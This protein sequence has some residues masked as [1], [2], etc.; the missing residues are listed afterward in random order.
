MDILQWNVSGLL[1]HCAEFKNLMLLE[2]PL[3]AAIQETHLRDTDVYNFSIKGYTM[4]QNNINSEY[5]KGGV[6]LYVSN[7]L[8]QRRVNLQTPL[9]AVAVHLKL[10][11]LSFIAVSL[12]LPPNDPQ[13]TLNNLENLVTELSPS[14]VVLLGDFNAHHTMWGSMSVSPR[15]QIIEKFLDTHSLCFLNDCSPTFQS[16]SYRSLS[17]IDLSVTSAHLTQHFQWTVSS[18]PLF[19]DHFPISIS[20]PSLTYLPPVPTIQK[21]KTELADWTKFNDKLGE[22][23]HDAPPDMTSFLSALYDT[24]V[25]IIPRS[26]S[27]SNPQI[28]AT[29][30]V[31]WNARCQWAKAV[32]RRALRAFEKNLMDDLLAQE[33]SDSRIFASNIFWEEKVKSWRTYVGSKINRFTPLTDIWHT[34]RSFGS[35]RTP[36]GAFPQLMTP[37]GIVSDPLQ[38]TNTFAKHFASISSTTIYPL[39]VQQNI[40]SLTDHLDFSSTET[41]FYNAPFTRKELETSLAKSNKSAPGPDGIDYSF[42]TNLTNQNQQ[43]LLSSINHLW[44][45]GTFPSEW[46]QS[47]IIPIKKEG[48]DELLAASYRPISLTNCSCKIMERMVNARLT[49][50]MET[51]KLYSPYQSGFRKNL[52]TSCNIIRL[53]SSVQKGFIHGYP[54]IATFLDLTSAFNKVH[55]GTILV[56]LNRIGIRGHMAKFITNFLQPRTFQ[57]KCKTTI[58]DVHTLDHGVP[59]GSVLSP[60]LFLLAI[61][62]IFDDIHRIY[63]SVHCSMFADDLAIWVT[64]KSYRE[65][66]E[67][68][69]DALRLISRWCERWGFFLSSTKSAAMV[70]KRGKSSNDLQLKIR[71]QAIPQ[72][73]KFKYLGILL[74]TRLTFHAH[75][76]ELRTRCLQRMN[77]LKCVSG[78]T[79]G[80]DRKSLTVL[81]CSLIRS[82]LDY[83]ATVI[84]VV[85]AT[86]RQRIES[87]QSMC[88]R[89][90][91]GAFRSTAV[92]ALQ[93]DVCLP[94]LENR[95]LYLLLRNYFQVMSMPNHPVSPCMNPHYVYNARCPQKA[96]RSIAIVAQSAQTEV[97]MCIPHI[98]PKPPALAY[99]LHSLPDVQYLINYKKSQTSTAE[100]LADF[101]EFQSAHSDH[102]FIY[103]DGSLQN[104]QVGSAV[105]W[106]NLEL[107]Y[108]LPDNASVYTAELYAIKR[109]MILVRDSRCP[110][111]VICTDSRSAL[112]ALQ[113]PQDIDHPL[114]YDILR[115]FFTLPRGQ[116]ITLLWI[117]GHCSIPG[118]ERADGA[119]KKGTLLPE[120]TNIKLP[121]CDVLS[122]LKQRFSS[123]LQIQW[124][125]NHSNHLFEIKPKLAT[126]QTSS[127][128]TRQREVLLTRLRCG[129]TR[130][131]HSYLFDN[132]PPPNCER[133]GSRLSVEHILLECHNEA[134]RRRDIANYLSANNLTPNLQNLLGNDHPELVELVLDFVC[135]STWAHKL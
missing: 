64:R 42:Y 81:Y 87:I 39:S 90:I 4:Y 83:S 53:I 14:P 97:N 93:A 134:L 75:I 56:K 43:Q 16:R 6:A 27:N 121:L 30:A 49:F 31:W 18:D 19:S 124:E 105:V 60:N 98:A 116:N 65:S 24:A 82:V 62:D 11:N 107:I 5:R 108:R 41:E 111:S 17:A 122:T 101:H 130:L 26:K 92:T 51:N 33:Y 71:N 38:V 85:C 28:Q 123:Y 114:V 57:V 12:Y 2:T 58:S 103:T 47:I 45:N 115:I 68:M 48:K 34:V 44:V 66:H 35:R 89:I 54:T 29:P 61:N 74:D 94:S 7:L 99:W 8:P 36:T 79:W 59:Q 40:E 128:N 72:V 69:Q 96:I 112:E 104:E 84:S 110:F 50:Y 135:L 129:H 106:L 88:L 67:I 91:S 118:N 21:W 22:K 113:R 133:C 125:N 20:I 46:L 117:P 55:K 120:V 80:A 32:R 15:G 25:D 9:N 23:L 109:A 77:I 102:T 13:I 70:F 3:I 63:P 52:N 100:I 119:A 10:G 95:R 78:S 132:D 37:D 86:S 76:E 1:S 126:W 131:T 127:Q 73:Q